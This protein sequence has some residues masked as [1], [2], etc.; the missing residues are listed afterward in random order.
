MCLHI[1]CVYDEHFHC[2]VGRAR[3]L[4]H[5]VQL[6]YRIRSRSYSPF[7]LQSSVA[8]SSFLSFAHLQIGEFTLNEIITKLLTISLHKL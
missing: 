5:Q 3:I 6:I 8:I 1:Q 2:K 4:I 7:S